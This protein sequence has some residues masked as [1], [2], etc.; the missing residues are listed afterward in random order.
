MRTDLQAQGSATSEPPLTTVLQHSGFHWDDG[1][2]FLQITSCK[3]PK[4][5]RLTLTIIDSKSINTG[6]IVTGVHYFG[7]K[8]RNHFDGVLRSFV[9]VHEEIIVFL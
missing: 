7:I 3:R 2:P 9:V 5:H 8:Q 6:V 4:K 1:R